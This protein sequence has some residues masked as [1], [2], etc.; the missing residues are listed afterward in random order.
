MSIPTFLAAANICVPLAMFGWIPVVLIIFVVLPPR[1]AVIASFLFAWLFLPMASFNLPALPPY[2]KV[3]AVSGGVLLAILLFD[4]HKVWTFRPRWVDVPMAVWCFSPFITSLVNGLGAYDGFSEVVTQIEGWGVPYVIGRLYFSNRE[5]LREL[6]I[7]L[8]I[9]GLIYVPFCLYEVRMSP[10][11]HLMLYGFRQHAFYQTARGDSWRPMV[12]MQHGLAVGMFMASASIVGFWLWR[13]RA[14]TSLWGMPMWALLLLLIVT[15]VLVKSMLA[16]VLLA[17][18]MGLALVIPILRW[19]LPIIALVVFP[20]L[21]IATRSTDLWSGRELV[22]VARM[23]SDSEQRAGSLETR[24]TSETNLSTKAWK[25]PVFGWGGWSRSSLTA[26]DRRDIE[27][28]GNVDKAIPD[29]YWII[30]FGK[31]GLVSLAAL[32]ALLLLP[33][34]LA[35]VRYPMHQWLTPAVAPMASVAILMNLYMIDCLM[36]AMSN[37]I[38][39][40]LCGGAICC[41]SDRARPPTDAISVSHPSGSY[42][43]GNF[44]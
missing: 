28:T 5:G 20:M 32:V 16:V 17:V 13:S 37:P 36:N 10:R 19:R 6:A 33:A 44:G 34:T 41:L 8:F 11:L 40:L 30:V 42:P 35:L 43:S 26:E 2:S 39:V 29:G 24:L 3:T 25:R 38:F 12:F 21:Y 4:F 18:G 7:G 15:T 14:I 9:G 1:R 27:Y 23:L 22:S 31:Y